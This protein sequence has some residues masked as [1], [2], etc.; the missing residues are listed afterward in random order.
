[1]APDR[2]C[3][4]WPKVVARMSPAS[5]ANRPLA[6]KAAR[7]PAAA[8]IGSLAGREPFDRFAITARGARV[9][10]SGT[11]SRPA[12]LTA[13]RPRNTRYVRVSGHLA[14]SARQPAIRG[15]TP[16]APTVI[17]VPMFRADTIDA[18]GSARRRNSIKYV[19][20]VPAARP[21]AT[22]ETRRPMSNPG[23][24]FHTASNPAAAIMIATLLSI[25]PRR[26]MRT[27]M[28]GTA[29]RAVMVPP[30][31]MAKTTVIMRDDR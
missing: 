8:G 14:H 17:A 30:A 7:V 25:T 29:R 4:G 9:P 21:T 1:M 31:K 15:P 20:A 26:P 2:A 24:A 5:P 22:P 13:P 16:R 23:N 18:F 10:V 19:I 11:T 27:A 28:R 3:D 12:R 6:A